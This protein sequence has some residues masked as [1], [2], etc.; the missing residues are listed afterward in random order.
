MSNQIQNYMKSRFG[1]DF[2]KTVLKKDKINLSCGFNSSATHK[3]SANSHIHFILDMKLNITLGKLTE[4][5]SGTGY[6]SWVNSI[7]HNIIKSTEIKVGNTTLISSSLDYGRYLDIL[8]ELKYSKFS[9]NE[10]K[11]IGKTNSSYGLKK[12]QDSIINLTI[13]LYFWF[14]EKY[15]HAYPHILSNEDLSFTLTTNTFDNLHHFPSSDSGNVKSESDIDVD[16]EL[17]YSYYTIDD[18]SEKATIQNINHYEHIYKETTQTYVPVL[19][20]KNNLIFK[21][22]LASDIIFGAVHADR[23]ARNTAGNALNFTTS[24]TLPKD[25]LNYSSNVRN[26]IGTFDFFNT[27]NLIIDG[28]EHYDTVQKSTDIRFGNKHLYQLYFTPPNEIHSSL[29]LTNVS[30]FKLTFTDIPS[31]TFVLYVF[32]NQFQIITIKN[33]KITKNLWS[34]TPSNIIHPLISTNLIDTTA[35]EHPSSAIKKSASVSSFSE[36]SIDTTDAQLELQGMMY[37]NI[38]TVFNVIYKDNKLKFQFILGDNVTQETIDEINENNYSLKF[39]NNP[40]FLYG[41]NKLGIQKI[42]YQKKLPISLRNILVKKIYNLLSAADNNIDASNLSHMIV[43][44]D[45][46]GIAK[47]LATNIDNSNITKSFEEFIKEEF[48]VSRIRDYINNIYIV[49]RTY[50]VT[51]DTIF[52]LDN[53]KYFMNR[54]NHK[55]IINDILENDFV[56]FEFIEESPEESNVVLIPNHILEEIPDNLLHIFSLKITEEKIYTKDELIKLFFEN[57]INP[58]HIQNILRLTK[59]HENDVEKHTIYKSFLQYIINYIKHYKQHKNNTTQFLKT[60]VSMYGIN[61]FKIDSVNRYRIKYSKGEIQIED[62]N[63]LMLDEDIKSISLSFNK[64]IG[65]IAEIDFVEPNL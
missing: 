22:L 16:I 58:K 3:I 21:N 5:S 10:N 56:K 65:L 55:K 53:N 20:T 38:F 2:K 61:F 37:D 64:E 23:H 15:E 51:I 36:L 40:R 7:G 34:K 6:I 32:V 12:Y 33:G 43:F 4:K 26:S 8:H 14:S 28:T 54:S 49:G 59:L 1:A 47:S 60:L 35:S 44:Q 25:V 19:L 41:I 63:N 48:F 29:N 27:C 13:P 24:S 50:E 52:D 45:I 62:I 57:I 42:D 39:I 17:E 9:S 30:N 18:E 31:D 46:L 11:Q